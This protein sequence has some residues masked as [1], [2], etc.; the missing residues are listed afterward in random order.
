MELVDDP[1]SVGLVAAASHPLC[2]CLVDDPLAVGLVD[3]VPRVELVVKVANV[4]VVPRV[5]LV[6]KVAN[7]VGS[8]SQ[9]K[10]A[11]WASA[12]LAT[13]L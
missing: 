5:E 3:V 12:N 10:D 13:S 9:T 2:V 7:V 8:T 4:D 11:V 1:L 6:V